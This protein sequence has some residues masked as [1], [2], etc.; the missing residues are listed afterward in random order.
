MLRH[1]RP[2]LRHGDLEVGEDLEQERLELG[3]CLVDLVDEQDHRLLGLD[4]REERARRQEPEREERVFL[5]GDLR[6]RVR[7][8]RRVGDQLADTLA[9]ELRVQELLGVLPL[10]ECLALV[11]SLV[12]LQPDERPAGDLGQRLGQL[13]LADAGRPLDEHRTAHAR[14]Q[15]DD[16]GHATA[17][18]VARVPEPL[19]DLLDGLEHDGSLF[20]PLNF[21]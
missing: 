2:Q 1:Q 5:A 17:R 4:R 11:E 6:D 16:R 19:L 14:G 15:E 7:Q 9:E 8:R 13:R 10:V 18:D 3:L 21:R 20:I 12:A